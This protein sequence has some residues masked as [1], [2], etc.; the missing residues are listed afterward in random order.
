[1]R[2]PLPQVVLAVLAPSALALPDFQF[3]AAEKIMDA[4]S[5]VR[6][7]RLAELDADGDLDLIVITPIPS[8]GL[9]VYK[10]DGAGNFGPA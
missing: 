9:Q 10:N 6:D 8:S 5:G 2:F 7:T 1:M 4:Q 3:G